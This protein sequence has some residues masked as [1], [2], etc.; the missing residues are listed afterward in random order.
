[1]LFSPI[2][3]LQA[4]ATSKKIV[5]THFSSKDISPNFF[6]SS[7]LLPLAWACGF[8]PWY[9]YQRTYLQLIVLQVGLSFLRSFLGFEQSQFVVESNHFIQWI[10]INLKCLVMVLK[11][12]TNGW[13]T[14]HIQHSPFNS[15][16]A[17]TCPVELT[18]THL[19]RICIF[20]SYI[21]S[22]FCRRLNPL[23][24]IKLDQ[25]NTFGWEESTKGGK[26]L[27]VLM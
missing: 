17:N 9:P 8:D 7:L 26:L 20:S 2:C 16:W 27:L 13:R 18:D 3:Q 6:N 24:K 10:I 12:K 25:N 23:H 14:H 4:T 1:M 11:I 22:W 15:I 5:N 19:Q 21:T